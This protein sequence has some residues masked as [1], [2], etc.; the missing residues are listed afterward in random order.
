MFL[1]KRREKMFTKIFWLVVV[2]L[3]VSVAGI[4]FHAAWAND[5]PYHV[6]RSAWVL[7]GCCLAFAVL[8]V[9]SYRNE[10]KNWN[11]KKEEER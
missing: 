10:S 7:G 11:E 3:E 1:V 9:V 6:A 2:L 5:L 4:F 8:A